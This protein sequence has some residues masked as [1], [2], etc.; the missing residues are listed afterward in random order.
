[1]LKDKVLRKRLNIDVWGTAVTIIIAPTIGKAISN[2]KL[3]KMKNYS[4]G[5]LKEDVNG[6]SGHALSIKRDD[7]VSRYYLFVEGS[8]TVNCF[9]TIPHESFHIAFCILKD[10]GMILTI[11]TQEAFAYLVGYIAQ[12]AL[13]LNQKWCKGKKKDSGKK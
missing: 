13:E 12:A 5:E 6:A 3:P 9:N 11:D 2:A 1:M 8:S 10:R 4:I 7:G